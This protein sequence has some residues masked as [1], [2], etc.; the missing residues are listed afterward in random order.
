MLNVQYC[1]PVMHIWFFFFKKKHFIEKL[2]N[3]GE[4]KN[5]RKIVIHVLV[6][7]D[8]LP[9]DVGPLSGRKSSVI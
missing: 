1:T 8:S 5:E 7:L 2:Q 6:H 4:P 9:V 3:Q